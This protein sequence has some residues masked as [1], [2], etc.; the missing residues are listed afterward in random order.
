MIKFSKNQLI[1]TI[2][3]IILAFVFGSALSVKLTSDYYEK[4]FDKFEFYHPSFNIVETVKTLRY[5]REKNLK[6]A[7]NYE[8]WRLDDNI[9]NLANN[10]KRSK[11]NDKK[12]MRFVISS[13][14]IAAAYRK[15]YPF[16]K[17]QTLSTKTIVNSMLRYAS[18]TP[19]K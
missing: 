13:L 9:V 16:E 14:R 4:L 8:E 6:A 3:L 11:T 19:K 10:M 1:T 7:A 2:L 12:L 17:Y 5:I 15:Q 18:K